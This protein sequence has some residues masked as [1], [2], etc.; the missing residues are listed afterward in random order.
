[1]HIGGGRIMQDY[2][3]IINDFLQYKRLMGYKYKTDEIVLN[4]IKKYLIDNNVENITQDVTENYARININL[5]PNT[6]SR[7][8][9]VFRELCSYINKYKN[10]NCYLIPKGL[11]PQNHYSYKPYIFSHE[12]IKK[13]YYNLK[14]FRFD[15]RYSYC[16]QVMYPLIIKILYQTGMRIG[17]V[18]KLTLENYNSEIGV[19]TLINTKNSEDR[20]VA[21]PDSLNTEILNYCNKFIYDKNQLLFKINTQSVERFFKKVM[22]LSDIKLGDYGPTLH[23]LRHTFIVHTIEKHMNTDIDMNV[24]FPILQAQVGHKSLEALSY[25][26]HT[27]NDLLNIANKVSERELSY[28][29]R[30]I[31]DNYE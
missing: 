1:M 21:I 20:N 27:T 6:I 17:E 4:E 7:N 15:Y 26:F 3:T 16:Y 9:G 2:N 14:K 12:E 18:L 30:K 8:M 19:F 24:L 31:G 25:Y 10:V 28:L 11:Y 23:C 29:I 22:H 13:I 5:N